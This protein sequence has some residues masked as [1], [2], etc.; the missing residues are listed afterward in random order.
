[1]MG[2]KI[3]S[4]SLLPHDLSLGDLVPQD[5]FYRRGR[6]ILALGAPAR[7][8]TLQTMCILHRSHDPTQARKMGHMT[9]IRA[10]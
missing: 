10:T 7:F 5:H 9:N 8:Y 3:R 2:T 4:L 1:M 6:G